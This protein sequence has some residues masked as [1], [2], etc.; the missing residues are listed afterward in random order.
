MFFADEDNSQGWNHTNFK[1]NNSGEA[2]VLRSMDGFS[3]ADSVHFPEITIDFSWGRDNDGTGPWREFTP[4]E[5]TPEYCNVCT[6]AVGEE[7]YEQF[8]SIYPNPIRVGM[9]LKTSESIVIY[10]INGRLVASSGSE[11]GIEI[12]LEPGAYI[13]WPSEGNGFMAKSQ[14]LIVLE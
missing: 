4:E 5:T 3:I 12:R 11:L 8:T 7:M 6:D 1:F 10:D 13:V 14:R 9:E 2:L